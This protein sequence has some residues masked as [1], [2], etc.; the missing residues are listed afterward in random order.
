M[1][2]IRNGKNNNLE[3]NKKRLFHGV[4]VLETLK[5]FT[6][7]KKTIL[8]INFI[9]S[10]WYT[11]IVN[12]EW[13]IKYLSHNPHI[14]YDVGEICTRNGNS[15]GNGNIKLPTANWQLEIRASFIG[16]RQSRT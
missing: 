3:N 7:R 5:G 11:V 14:V 1:L 9:I 8:N 16:G 12:I 15:N 10:F 13:K 4:I 6:G 2:E